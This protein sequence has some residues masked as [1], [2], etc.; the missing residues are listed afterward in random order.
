MAFQYIGCRVSSFAR[1]LI[2]PTCPVAQGNKSLA[3]RHGPDGG[4]FHGCQQKP[5]SGHRCRS[6]D[7]RAQPQSGH[8]DSLPSM[9]TR[10]TATT[11]YDSYSFSY[12]CSSSYAKPITSVLVLPLC[13]ICYLL[14]TVYYVLLTICYD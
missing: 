3:S 10:I 11:Y 14:L 5:P 8:D 1:T 13:T 9:T 6:S 2:S 12:Y 4:G 7:V